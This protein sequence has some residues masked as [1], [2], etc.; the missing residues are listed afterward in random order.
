MSNMLGVPQQYLFEILCIFCDVFFF[1]LLF[2]RFNY[3]LVSVTAKFHPAC[4]LTI[5]TFEEKCYLFIRSTRGAYTK[6]KIKQMSDGRVARRCYREKEKKAKRKKTAHKMLVYSPFARVLLNVTFRSP[7][8]PRQFTFHKDRGQNR[9][10][11]YK[12]S[13][14]PSRVFVAIRHAR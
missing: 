6:R 14:K 1:F 4:N 10:S 12:F 11:C 2:V 9:V 8:A 7:I 13:R 3:T 5:K